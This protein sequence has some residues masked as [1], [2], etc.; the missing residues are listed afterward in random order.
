[1]RYQSSVTSLSWIPS[2]AI[3]GGTR[4]PFDVGMAHYDQAPPD[5][6]GDLEELRRNDRFR[7]ANR[8]LATMQVN[9]RGE[10]VGA[11][12]RGAGMIGSTTVKVGPVSKVFEAV[13][14]P[15][16]QMKPVYGDGWV[17]F[18]QTAGGRTGMP[19]PR[20]VRRAPFIQ[21][22]APL[23]WT[24]LSLTMYTNGESKG[25][26]VGASR[27]PRHWVYDEQ[28]KLSAKSGLID[29]NDWYRKSFGKQTPWGHQDSDAFVTTVESALE[30]NLSHKLMAGA[31][32]PK[33]RK[34]KPGTVL[35]QQGEQSSDVF[36][37][38][39]G[40]LRVDVD[41]VRLA[42]YGPGAMLGERAHLE[43]GS[44]TSSLVAVT[45]C[46]VASVP[47]ESFDRASLEELSSGHH[48]EDS[49]A[50]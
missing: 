3:Q 20:R 24:T 27:F 9:A 6:I 22:Q 23:A 35:V 38:L 44:R 46:R 29:F 16:I 25:V 7:F 21:W 12:Y 4:L 10:I 39:D 41:G 43:G 15:D 28:G 47:A 13:A 1:M 40:V 36:L 31:A 11:S 32:K 48:R 8:L 19:A 2:E 18:T 45:E 37:I 33:I 42:E 17:R 5:E 14:L 30:R 49:N 34:V 26:L 50:G